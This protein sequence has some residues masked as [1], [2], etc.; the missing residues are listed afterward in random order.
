MCAAVGGASAYTV[1]CVWLLLRHLG[2]LD[3]GAQVW[4]MTGTA[5]HMEKR[6]NEAT[7]CSSAC[8]C[9]CLCVRYLT[10]IVVGFRRC[11]DVYCCR[12]FWA[13]PFRA[14]ENCCYGFGRSG[15]QPVVDG[16]LITFWPFNGKGYSEDGFWLAGFSPHKLCAGL[17]ISARKQALTCENRRYFLS[18]ID[19]CSILICG[20]NIMS[21]FRF[22]SAT[23]NYN[24]REE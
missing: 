17:G 16:L 19:I 4:K 1:D 9:V 10:V 3:T 18:T 11:T 6:A 2:I 13:G 14:V 5:V 21:A 22:C 12:V 24:S 15:A 20:H 7:C 8:A 23:W